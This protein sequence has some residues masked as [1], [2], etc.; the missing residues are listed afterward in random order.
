VDARVRREHHHL[1]GRNVA[2]EWVTDPHRIITV[3]SEAHQLIT[4]GWIDVEG[5]DARGTIR[6]HWA[7][8]VQAKDKPFQIRSRRLSQERE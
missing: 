2:P 5:D 6:F 1:A 7:S 3:C 8:H 4:A